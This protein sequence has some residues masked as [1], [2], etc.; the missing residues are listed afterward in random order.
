M[1]T[2]YPVAREKGSLGDEIPS[3]IHHLKLITKKVDHR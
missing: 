3:T 2:G 1:E